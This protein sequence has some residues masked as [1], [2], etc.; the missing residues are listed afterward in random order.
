MGGIAVEVGIGPKILH[1]AP[2]HIHR[3]ML[4]EE[5]YLLSQA[6]GMADIIAVH[7][8]QVLAFYVFESRV[9]GT[10][11]AQVVG[12]ADEAQA[13]VDDGTNLGNGV[14]G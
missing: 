5:S 4:V 12:V 13:R 7:L 2:H 14:I 6:L 3:R 9:V 11:T 10:R 1:E 8:G